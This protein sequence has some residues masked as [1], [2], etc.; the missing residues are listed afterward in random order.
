MGK[1]C[2]SINQEHCFKS[3]FGTEALERNHRYFFEIK[4]V[5]GT[6]FKFGIATELAK[7]TPNMS[8]SDTDQGFAYFSNGALR[9]ASKGSGARYGDK[10]K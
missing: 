3:A 9:H 8:F 6:N 4:C 1:I 5:R 2:R 7:K 10:F